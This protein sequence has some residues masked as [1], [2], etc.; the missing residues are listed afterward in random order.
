MCVNVGTGVCQCRYR[1]VSMLV[2][3]CVNVGTGVCQC[4]GRLDEPFQI[5]SKVV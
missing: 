5:A 4:R 2:Q 1:C 3:V